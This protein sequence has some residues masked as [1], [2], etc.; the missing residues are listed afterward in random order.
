MALP[1]TL[2]LEI[3]TP[4]RVIA[5]DEVDEIQIPGS[6]GYLGVLPGHTSLL[7]TLQVGE[8]WYRRGDEITYLAVCVWLCRGAA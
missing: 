2:T 6:Q 7:T 1:T 3:V 4:E 5:H 8:A